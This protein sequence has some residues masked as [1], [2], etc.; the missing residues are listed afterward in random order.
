LKKEVEIKDA[1][2]LDLKQRIHKQEQRIDEQQSEITG[3]RFNIK[4]VTSKEHKLKDVFKFYTGIAYCTFIALFT[5]LVPQG[6]NI[7]F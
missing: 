2:I 6:E 3:K 4:A 7:L 5:T 1:I